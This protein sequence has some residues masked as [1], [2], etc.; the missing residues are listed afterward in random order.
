MKAVVA[1][2]QEIFLHLEL[3][4]VMYV[5]LPQK[6]SQQIWNILGKL[7]N[8]E[9]RWLSIYKPESKEQSN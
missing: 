6:K 7:L 9:E 5:L 4:E 2:K 3:K 1:E 8:E